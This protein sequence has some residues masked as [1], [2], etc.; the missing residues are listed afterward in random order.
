MNKKQRKEQD[1]ERLRDAIIRNIYTMINMVFIERL[2]LDIDE[3]SIAEVCCVSSSDIMSTID[4][5]KQM[6][7]PAK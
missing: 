7:K 4:F 3:D 2:K 6:N 5:H 1:E